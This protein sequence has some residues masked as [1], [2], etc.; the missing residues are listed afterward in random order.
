MIPRPPASLVGVGAEE[1]TRVVT[2]LV[3][4]GQWDP[5]RSTVLLAY[6]EAYADWH[7][8]STAARGKELIKQGVTDQK[9]A[10]FSDHFVDQRVI[11]RAAL[12]EL[13]RPAP[14]AKAPAPGSSPA[15]AEGIW[16]RQPGETAR[17]YAAF[18]SYREL[19]EGRSLVK[20][21]QKQGKKRALVE[22]WSTRHDWVARAHAWD[23]HQDAI[24]RALSTEAIQ[25]MRAKHASTGCALHDAG[26]EVLLARM[27]AWRKNGGELPLT[28]T[29]I[30]RMVQVGAA[31]EQSARGQA[32]T[33]PSD[34]TAEPLEAWAS[35]LEELLTPNADTEI[36]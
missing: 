14:W 18:C 12:E 25:T 9:E 20:V 27:E 10:K 21:G 6:C 19:G 16:C 5:L 23:E 36:H 1:W 4:R 29:D 31:L 35:R 11:I 32:V 30:V 13:L 17:A 33:V 2:L 15:A 26:L 24:A 34:P 22:T 8:L 7:R 28:P 3:D